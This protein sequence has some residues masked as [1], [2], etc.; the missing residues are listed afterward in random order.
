M[1]KAYKQLLKDIESAPTHQDEALLA[2]QFADKHN[3]HFLGFDFKH[4]PQFQPISSHDSAD[5][6]DITDSPDSPI[7][8]L[9]NAQIKEL[10]DANGIEYPAR[11]NKQTLLELL[12]AQ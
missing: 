5:T 11:A 9:T 4:S 6:T 12:D 8:E 1:E 2:K 3:L 10:L 7:S